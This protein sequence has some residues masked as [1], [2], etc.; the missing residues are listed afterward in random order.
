[1]GFWDDW[2]SARVGSLWRCGGLIVY[3][4]GR[5]ALALMEID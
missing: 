4:A 3:P 1:M 2:I 5:K